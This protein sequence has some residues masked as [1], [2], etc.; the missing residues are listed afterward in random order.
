MKGL[1]TRPKRGSDTLSPSDRK[2]LELYDRVNKSASWPGGGIKRWHGSRCDKCENWTA[3]MPEI[4]TQSAGLNYCAK[5]FRG[6]K[7]ET[8]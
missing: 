3:C 7:L 4:G 2:N 6:F 1:D 5:M 8:A